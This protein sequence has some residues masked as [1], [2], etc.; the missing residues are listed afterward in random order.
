MGD[1]RADEDTDALNRS[2]EEPA[3]ESGAGYGSHAPGP[4]PEPDEA[5]D[6]AES[7]E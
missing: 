6:R 5:K 4:S 2:G 3:A 7:R 1:H